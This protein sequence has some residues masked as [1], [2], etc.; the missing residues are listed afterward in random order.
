M[1]LS[2]FRNQ[3][4]PG[5]IERLAELS[6]ILSFVHAIPVSQLCAYVG[7]SESPTNI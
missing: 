6:G 3:L 4:P 2:I 5:K 1:L 7:A